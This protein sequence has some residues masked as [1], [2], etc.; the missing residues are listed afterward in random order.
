MITLVF[1]A[2]IFMVCGCLVLELLKYLVQY[3]KDAKVKHECS[4]YESIMFNRE[5]EKAYRCSDS[6]S[7]NLVIYRLNLGLTCGLGFGRVLVLF[8]RSILQN[9]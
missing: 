8:Y 4:V 2:I 1:Q 7:D 6:K 5:L 9:G 3:L